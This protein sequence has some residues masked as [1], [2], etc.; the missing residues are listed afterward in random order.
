MTRLRICKIQRIWVRSLKAASPAVAFILLDS[1]VES[2]HINTCRC[3]L[4]SFLHIRVLQN[5]QT[6]DV[7][8]LTLFVCG[9]NIVAL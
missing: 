5:L 8:R 2:A 1:H 9:I 3:E 7:E 4:I 6:K